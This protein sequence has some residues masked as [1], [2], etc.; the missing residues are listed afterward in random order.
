MLT[1][2]WILLHYFFPHFLCSGGSHAQFYFQKLEGQLSWD[3]HHR[4]QHGHCGDFWNGCSLTT[5]M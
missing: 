3:S 5:S 1:T 2:F 4:R